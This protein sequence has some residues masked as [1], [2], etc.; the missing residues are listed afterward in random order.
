MKTKIMTLMTNLIITMSPILA[1]AQDTASNTIA[2][3]KESTLFGLRKIGDLWL[4]FVRLIIAIGVVI[5]LVLLSKIL[6]RFVTKRIRANSIW[7]DEYTR[8]ISGLIGEIIFYT[9][10]IF[11]ILIGFMI[12]QVDFG[13]ILWGISFGLWFAFKDILGNLIAGVLVLTN[14]DF[15]LG[16]IIEI[17]YENA[18]YFWRIE[19]ITIRYTVIRQ[20]D[21]R[22]VIVPNLSMVLNP[23]KTYDAEELVRL[24]IW[25]SIHYETPM[26]QW[27]DIIKEAIN[28]VSFVKEH[29]STKV[30]VSAMGNHGLEVFCYFFFD[31]AWGMLIKTAKGIVQEAIFDA[32]RKKGIVIPYPHTTITVDHNDKNLL[33]SAL[34]VMKEGG[35]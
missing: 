5:L 25:L 7:D 31:P 18:S 35:K 14:K 12:L 29:A 13:R 6:S 32:F 27:L 4:F 2:T 20:F 30:H 1:M 3:S 26:P 8:K 28:S 15:R 33:G 11:S 16:D 10:T 19:E 17:D 21:L 34:Y 22:K 9:L 24:E 23:I